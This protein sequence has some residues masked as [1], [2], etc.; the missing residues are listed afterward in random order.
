MRALRP[1]TFTL[2]WNAVITAETDGRPGRDAL[3]ELVG[4]H[5]KNID[6]GIVTTAASENTRKRRMPANSMEFRS[7]LAAAGLHH[8]TM[9]HTASVIGLTYIGLSRIA[10]HDYKEMT[11]AIWGIVKPKG[12][13][14][15]RRVFESNE[16]IPAGTPIT[17]PEYAK[18]RN[19][20]CDVN[21][22]Y[23]HLISNRD[24]FVSGD[25]KNF[26]G[27]SGQKLNQ[28]GIKKICSYDEAES[29]ARD[30]S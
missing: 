21:S 3:L 17:A 22:I 8:L 26:I 12:V 9:V 2:E 24:V 4:M 6:V 25:K 10:P 15:D 5:G 11:N 14:W 19:K 29:Y 1:I 28:L 13:P 23:A 27:E 7:R 30:Y 16:G 18:W 20:W